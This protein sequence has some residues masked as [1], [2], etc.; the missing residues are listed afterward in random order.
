MLTGVPSTEAG[1]DQ[2]Y[3]DFDMDGSFDWYGLDYTHIRDAVQ[4]ELPAANCR[5]QAKILHVGCG[6]SVF[7]EELWKDGFKDVTNVDV[8]EVVIDQCRQKHSHGE[9]SAM[10][11]KTMDATN[12]QYGDE[13]FDLIIDKGT[14]D[15]LMCMGVSGSDK[16]RRMVKEAYRVCKAGGC[17]IVISYGEYA[18]R[19][20]LMNQSP[21][22]SVKHV[23]L[24]AIHTVLGAKVHVYIGRKRGENELFHVFPKF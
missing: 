7:P 16:G 10:E 9:L 24:S 3:E 17:L 1:W 4:Q 22:E 14:V 20:A 21:W 18:Q 23:A 12:L 8:S 2:F 6:N 5:L 19:L 15:A 13:V 11:F